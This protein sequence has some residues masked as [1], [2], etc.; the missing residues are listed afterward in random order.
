MGIRL[1][2][3]AG[4]VL[5]ALILA[6]GAGLVSDALVPVGPQQVAHAPADEEQPAAAS[7][8]GGAEQQTAAAGGG[9]APAGGGNALALVATADPAAGQ[10][11]AKKCVACHTFDPGGANRVG[12]NLAGIVGADI[13]AK[14]GFRYSDALTGKPG[15]WSYEALDAFITKPTAFAPGTKMTFAGVADPKERAAILAYLRSLS[16]SAPPPPQG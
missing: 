11:A 6:V 15:E 9:G 8:E 7:G 5:F 13:A 2:M 3:I 12:P 1:Q 16:P 14:P 10:A 4:A